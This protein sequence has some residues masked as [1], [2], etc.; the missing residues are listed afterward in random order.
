MGVR[1]LAILAA[2]GLVG[3][4]TALGN[5]K[6]AADYRICLTLAPMCTASN[7]LYKPG[8]MNLFTQKSRFRQGVFVGY[9]I[10]SDWG[11]ATARGLGVATIFT[12]K[13]NCGGTYSLLPEQGTTSSDLTLI[14]ATD[15]KPWH[16]KMVYSRVTARVPAIGWYEVYKKGL[17]PFSQSLP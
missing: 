6:T 14:V 16:G 12:C 4:C 1:I 5:T 2:C 3:G 9:I 8:G 7:V 15:P 17:L 13:R 10:W 11:A